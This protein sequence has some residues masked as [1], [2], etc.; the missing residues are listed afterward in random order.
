LRLL[1]Q[2]ESEER[3]IQHIEAELKQ[4]NHQEESERS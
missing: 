2:I 4:L 3:E 1:N